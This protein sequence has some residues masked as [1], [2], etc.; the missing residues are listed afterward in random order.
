MQITGGQVC[1]EPGFCSAVVSL[2]T[3][4]LSSVLEGPVRY[5]VLEVTIMAGA[6][7]SQYNTNTMQYKK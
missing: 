5:C 1:C 4:K 6:P 2:S 7:I 3:V